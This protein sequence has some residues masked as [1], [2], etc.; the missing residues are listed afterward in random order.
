MASITA[1]VA[2]AA[3]ICT[4]VATPA[5]AVTA[6]IPAHRH[7]KLVIVTP[8]SADTPAA[9]PSAAPQANGV[10]RPAFQALIASLASQYGVEP[11]LIEAIVY[12]E[13]SFDRFAVSRQGAQGLMQLMPLTAAR[14]GVRDAFDPVENIRGGIQYVRFLSDLFTNQL[15]LVLAAYNAGEGA[16]IRHQ[17]MPPY[18]E[19]QAYVDRVLAYYRW[20]KSAVFPSAAQSQPD[21]K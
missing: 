8:Q 2:A 20:S 4:M 16:V 13:S 18:T 14:F 1:R 3:L 6:T 19:T 11:A 17:G 12:A 10:V 7:G 15:A 5:V 21:S 9:A